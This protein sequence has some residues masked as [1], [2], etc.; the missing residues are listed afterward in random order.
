[1]SETDKEQERLMDEKEQERLI[2]ELTDLD[3]A[4]DMLKLLRRTRMFLATTKISQF[5]LSEI[6][7]LLNKFK[8]LKYE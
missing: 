2:A 6:D 7:D 4:L 8:D 5:D 3:I 1:M